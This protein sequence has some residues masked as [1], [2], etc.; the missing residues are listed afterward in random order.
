MADEYVSLITLEV[1][2]QEITDFN[3][4]K[5]P[6]REVRK[7]IKLMN[8]TGFITLNPAYTDGTIEYVVPKDSSEFDFDGVTD[9][10]LTIDKG[11]GSR[12][13]YSGVVVTEIDEPEYGDEKEAIRKI[14]WG[15]AKRT[16]T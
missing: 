8:K 4:V 16:E 7:V 9:G 6:K 5:E 1:N 10:T 3:K 2:G 13:T 11:N 15:A 14:T 12:V